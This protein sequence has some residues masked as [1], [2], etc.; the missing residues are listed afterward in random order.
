MNYNCRHSE[1]PLAAVRAFFLEGEQRGGK[2]VAQVLLELGQ[3]GL[4]DGLGGAAAEGGEAR[5][6][7]REVGGVHGM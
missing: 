4:A 7:G 3:G 6:P 1:D 2:E 5:A